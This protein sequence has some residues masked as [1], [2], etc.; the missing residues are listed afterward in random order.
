MPNTW[1]P[2]DCT[3]TEVQFWINFA[4]NGDTIQL[5]ASPGTWTAGSIT[6]SKALT[7][8]G[9]STSAPADPTRGAGVSSTV[10]DVTGTP[11][12]VTMTINE[13]ASG[14]IIFRDIEFRASNSATTEIHPVQ[15]NGTWL[16]TRPVIFYNCTVVLDD[17]TMFQSK[18]AGNLIFSHITCNASYNSFLMTAVDITVAGQAS[19]TTADSMGANDTTGEMNVYIESCLFNGGCN[20]ILDASDNAR[21]VLRHNRLVW[22]GGFNSHGNDTS[23]YG[24]RH[25]DIYENSFEYPTDTPGWPTGVLMSPYFGGSYSCNVGWAIW[26]RGGTGVIYN[27]YLDY[28]NTNDGIHGSAW[29]DGKAGMNA[30][31]RAIQDVLNNVF[32]GAYPD[33]CEYVTYPAPRQLGQGNNGVADFTDPIWVWGNTGYL[34][35]FGAAGFTWG[36]PCALPDY[37]VFW[38]EGRDYILSDGGYGAT[39]KPG[40]TAYTYPHPLITALESDSSSSALGRTSPWLLF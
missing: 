1:Y 3:P 10:I 11:G 26:L 20:G 39:A 32:P 5:P 17:A 37:T 13:S 8:K 25:F 2:A 40:Y 7:I 9:V 24:C 4:A 31:I 22:S 6:V 35:P 28:I 16:V 15:I 30:T 38:Q 12:S 23:Q 34:V 36:N 33:H 21:M 18:V 27:N 29:G 14:L 19:W